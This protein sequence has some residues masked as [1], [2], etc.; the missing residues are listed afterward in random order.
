MFKS[1]KKRSRS[2]SVIFLKNSPFT[3]PD[4]RR[5]YWVFAEIHGVFDY[6]KRRTSC[7]NLRAWLPSATIG[8]KNFPA[9][10]AETCP[11]VHAYSHPDIIFSMNR[12]QGSIR[13]P[14]GF[15]ESTFRIAEKPE[16]PLWWPTLSWWSERCSRVA[17]MSEGKLLMTDTPANLKKVM[18]G[19]VVEIVCSNIRRS[20]SLLKT[21]SLVKEV[22]AFADRWMLSC[23][24]LPMILKQCCLILRINQ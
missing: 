1:K 4:H 2:A 12:R 24:R 22:Q 8:G 16:S 9:Y 5:K 13:L 7:W 14:P 19:E 17:L 3:G 20:F 21:H 11:G 10:E 15:L 6:K 18:N 23:N